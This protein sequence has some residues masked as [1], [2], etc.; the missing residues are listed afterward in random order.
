MIEVVKTLAGGTASGRARR[1]R[2]YSAVRRLA[3]QA[4]AAGFSFCTPLP[5]G[6]HFCN[7]CTNFEESLFLIPTRQC[8]KR[9]T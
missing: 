6:P 7:I 3:P 8:A 9:D 5:P 2:A 1:I 4:W